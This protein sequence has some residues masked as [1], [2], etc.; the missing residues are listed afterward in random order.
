VGEVYAY[1]GINATKNYS[2]DAMLKKGMYNTVLFL[3]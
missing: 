3:P 2:Y 1:F